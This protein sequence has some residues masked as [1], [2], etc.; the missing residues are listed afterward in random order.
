MCRQSSGG[1]EL[2]LKEYGSRLPPQ[3]LAWVDV[4]P[5][6]CRPHLLR[7]YGVKAGALGEKTSEQSVHVL[8]GASFKGAVWMAEKHNGPLALAPV[9]RLDALEVLKLT[10]VVHRD[11]FE[12]LISKPSAARYT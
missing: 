4:H 5:P 10:A 11:G 1:Q 12:Q 7:L 2:F 6:L 9:G 3:Q 8:I